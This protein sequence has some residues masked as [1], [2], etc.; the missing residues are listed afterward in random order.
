MTAYHLPVRP[1][2]PIDALNRRAAATGSIRYAEAAAHADYNGHHV[3]LTWNSYR[4]YY[5]AEYFWAE[6]VVIAR[7]SFAECLD[8]TLREYRKGALGASAEVC[9]RDDDA[10]AVA[11]CE[12]TEGLATGSGWEDEPGG[13]KRLVAPWRTWQHECAEESARDAANPGAMVMLFDWALMQSAK[14]RAE[15]E[16]ALRV[17]HGRVY[18]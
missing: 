16:A 8:A 2:S 10:E 4:S 13:M 17:R 6:R 5:V 7:G 15:Y 18:Q 1:Y 14:S 9:P 3:R 11:L 12:A